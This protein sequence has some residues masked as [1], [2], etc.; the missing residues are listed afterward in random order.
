MENASEMSYGKERAILQAKY[1]ATESKSSAIHI[2][3]S[4]A[5]T[6]SVGYHSL[7]GLVEVHLGVSSFRH[8]VQRRAASSY[9]R[10]Y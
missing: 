6:G 5:W 1:A 3:S 8:H 2:G 7:E 9:F 10:N 4:G